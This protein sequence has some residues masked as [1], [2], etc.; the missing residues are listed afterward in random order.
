VKAAATAGLERTTVKTKIKAGNLA[1]FYRELRM[2]LGKAAS[3]TLD[4]RETAG[5]YG[6]GT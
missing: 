3:S 5:S 1:V 4:D 2:R 6:A